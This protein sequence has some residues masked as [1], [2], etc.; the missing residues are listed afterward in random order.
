[1]AVSVFD[2]FKIGI[3]PSSSHTVGPMRAARQFVLRLQQGGL[4]ERTVTVRCS[5]HGSLGATGKGHASDVAVLLGLCGHEP[6]TVAVD[7]IADLVDS[8]FDLE[9]ASQATA[10]A[11]EKLNGIRQVFQ[12]RGMTAQGNNTF[13]RQLVAVRIEASHVAEVYLGFTT[14]FDEPGDRF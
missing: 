14:T 2:L 11:Q 10:R 7:S 3:G 1:M 5:L 13:W 8:Y 9:R 6:D 4:L 12:Q